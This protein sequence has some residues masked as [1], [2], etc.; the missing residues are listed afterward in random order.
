MAQTALKVDHRTLGLLYLQWTLFAG[1]FILYGLAS[2]PLWLHILIG[3]LAIHLAFTIWH[4]AAH[5]TISNLRVV[6]DT[7]GILGMFPYMTPYFMQS[8]LIS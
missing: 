1:N 4:E 2:L 5:G 7:A 6:N 3:I 8:S